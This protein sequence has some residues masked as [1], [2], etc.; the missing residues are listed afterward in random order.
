MKF[1][2]ITAAVATAFLVTGCDIGGTG[3]KT[4]DGKQSSEYINADAGSDFSTN[5]GQQI[6]LT[7]A[8]NSSHYGIKSLSWVQTFGDPLMITNE[9]CALST[10]SSVSGYI[11]KGRKTC[12]LGVKLPKLSTVKSYGFRI[13]GSDDNGNSAFDEIIVTVNPTAQTILKVNAGTN[14]T[15]ESEST[16]TMNCLAIGGDSGPEGKDISYQWTIEENNTGGSITLDKP[17]ESKVTFVAPSLTENATAK[18]KCIVT[19]YYLEQASGEVV[20]TVKPI[21]PQISASAGAAQTAALNSIVTLDGS[22]TTARDGVVLYYSWKQVSG[23]EAVISN[24]NSAVASFV[25]K[26]AGEYTF[27]LSVKNF[28][29]SGAVSYLPNEQSITT[30]IV[31]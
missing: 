12:S 25:A 16:A 27:Q 11:T 20:V 30:V 6:K 22:A 17:N 26:T 19:D 29:N 4:S 7:G 2:L 23:P 14:F 9:D 24:A 8:V 1:N 21:D 15:V 18:F 10:D 31:Q 5:A 28:P 3:E 13:S